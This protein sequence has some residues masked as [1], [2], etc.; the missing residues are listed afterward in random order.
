MGR[1][2]LQL[3]AV[4]EPWEVMPQ[5]IVNEKLHAANE[6]GETGHDGVAE[7]SAKGD[8]EEPA[9]EGGSTIHDLPG[10]A[11]GAKGEEEVA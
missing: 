7:H 9:S 11:L 1:P 3:A 8:H 2:A 4:S 5:P 6:E 10:R